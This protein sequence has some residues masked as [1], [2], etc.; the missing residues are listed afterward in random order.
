MNGVLLI[1]IG[2]AWRRLALGGVLRK[3]AFWC[4]VYGAFANWAAT[5][6]AALTG[7]VSMMPLAGG[8]A[9]GSPLAERVVAFLLITLTAAMLAGAGLLVYGLRKTYAPAKA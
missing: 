4:F 3:V 2:L 6:I 7:A 9:S 5:L 8:E 1:V